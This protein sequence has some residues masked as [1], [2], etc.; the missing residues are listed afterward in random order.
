M[1]A[2]LVLDGVIAVLL[3]AMIFCGLAFYRRLG[4]LRDSRGEFAAL[5]ESFSAATERAGAGVSRI[6]ET[7]ERSHAELD[8]RIETA[9]ALCDDLA[10]LVERGARLADRLEGQ[11]GAP[12]GDAATWPRSRPTIVGGGA[13]RAADKTDEADEMAADAPAG[14]APSSVER[15]LAR[16]LRAAREG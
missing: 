2:G 3:V 13:A 4:E 8:E 1:T 16:T 12:A 5:I 15:E 7:G 9:R 10:F 11:A 6:L 14:A